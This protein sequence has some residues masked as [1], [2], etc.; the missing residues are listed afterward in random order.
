MT[1]IDFKA[2]KPDLEKIGLKVAN[3]LFREQ[4]AYPSG[5]PAARYEDGYSDAV[6]FITCTAEDHMKNEGIRA[7]WA[8]RAAR[9]VAVDAFRQRF[10][11]LKAAYLA[12]GGGTA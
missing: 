6:G 2:F 7:G 9:D 11:A 3:A 12:E 5:T 1:D 8:K 10:S 4:A